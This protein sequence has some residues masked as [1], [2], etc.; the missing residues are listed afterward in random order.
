MSRYVPVRT[1]VPTVGHAMY[2]VAG[3]RAGGR[4][5]GHVVRT[6][7]FFPACTCA[8]LHTHTHMRTPLFPVTPPCILGKTMPPKKK[9]VS[10]SFFELRNHRAETGRRAD[11]CALLS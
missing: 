11:V 1:A 5:G 4:P 8:A 2:C 10:W 7:L 6:F 3:R 9:L